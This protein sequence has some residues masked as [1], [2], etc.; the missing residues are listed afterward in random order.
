MYSIGNSVGHIVT[1]KL[2][3]IEEDIFF[4]GGEDP[5]KRLNS[6]QATPTHFRATPNSPY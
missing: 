2:S 3:H 5:D 6:Y 1:L 4:L